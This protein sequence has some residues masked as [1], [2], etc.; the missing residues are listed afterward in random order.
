MGATEES[1]T[2]I[3]QILLHL[4]KT[5]NSW[6]EGSSGATNFTDEFANKFLLVFDKF[7]DE[8]NVKTFEKNSS[9]PPE[10]ASIASLPW[11]P[12]DI[13]V[14]TAIH[15]ENGQPIF[16]QFIEEF[17]QW[18]I[19]KK[20]YGMNLG[21]KYLY[22]LAAKFDDFGE[23]LKKNFDSKGNFIGNPKDKIKIAVTN[24]RIDNQ[25]T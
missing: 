9:M 12:P 1:G 18:E 24:R 3:L 2:W 6:Y 21:A 7:F 17:E 23:D 16:N 11:M 13:I 5:P 25:K 19:T 22:H 10:F 20:K 4:D 8:A 14:V 15:T